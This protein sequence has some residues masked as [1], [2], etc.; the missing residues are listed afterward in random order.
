LDWWQEHTIGSLRIAATPAMHFSSRGIGDRGDTLW[1][2][3]ALIAANGRRAFFAAIPGT[4]P[5]SEAIGARYGPFDVAC[6][7]S[8]PTSRVGSCA[9]ST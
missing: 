2:G 6:S 7:R 3:F 4:I 8:A 1:C 9:I 5:T